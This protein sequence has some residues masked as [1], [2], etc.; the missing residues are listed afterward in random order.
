MLLVR[1]SARALC[2]WLLVLVFG[3]R[4]GV[5]DTVQMCETLTTSGEA[6]SSLGAVCEVRSEKD[7]IF[8]RYFRWSF[9]GNVVLSS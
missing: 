4:C 7:F 1:S 2:D 9:T 6:S 5:H 8:S 3:V